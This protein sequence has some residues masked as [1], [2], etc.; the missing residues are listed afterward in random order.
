MKKATTKDTK[1]TKP[2]AETLDEGNADLFS[3]ENTKAT[4]AQETEGNRP[5]QI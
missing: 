2:R 4:E 3:E 1:S 5:I